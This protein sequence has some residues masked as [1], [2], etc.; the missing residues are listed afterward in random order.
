MESFDGRKVGEAA[1][2]GIYV[3]APFCVSHCTYCD[4]FTRP[5]TGEAEVTRFVDSLVTEMAATATALNLLGRKADTLYVGGGTPSLLPPRDL[6]RILEQVRKLF[7][8]D[9]DAE[10]SLEA[11]PESVTREKM[12]AYRESGVNRISLGVQSFQRGIL[13]TLGRAHGPEEAVRAVSEIRSS[14]ISNLSLDLMLALP[15]QTRASLEADLKTAVN[16]EPDHLSAYLLEM[17]KE[18]ALR[19]RIERG[20][21][22]PPSQEESAEMYETVFTLLERSGFR[23]YEISSFCRPGRECRHNVKYWTDRPFVGFGRSAWSY[24]EGKRWRVARDLEGYLEAARC[25][26]PPVHETESGG[27]KERMEEAIFAGLRLLDGVDLEAVGRAYSVA[28]P[29]VLYGPALE[30][31]EEAGLVRRDGPRLSLTRRGLPLANEVFRVFV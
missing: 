30:E 22:A 26:V 19:I 4:F 31:L 18:S 25:G 8:V 28:D 12:R 3:H 17:D 10:V 20:E 14:G 1:P 7:R 5:F 13:A 6:D 11:N 15:G 23:H 9:G 16:L 29:S 21:L 24:L 2:L 27:R